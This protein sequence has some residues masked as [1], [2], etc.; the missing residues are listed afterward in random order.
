M[1]KAVPAPA[2]FKAPAL[3]H[4]LHKFG[5][6]LTFIVALTA[7]LGSLYFSEIRLF[8]PC[9]LCWYQRILMYPI[10]PVSLVGAIKKDEYLPYYVLPLSLMGISVSIYH[11]LL[12]NR[13]IP[14][15]DGCTATGVSCVNPPWVAAGFIT[16]A[17][18]ALIAFLII[19]LTMVGTLWA[20]DQV[21]REEE[22]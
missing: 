16:I 9:K 14:E 11:Y 1:T 7:A 18:L 17:F 8:I 13:I 20:N 15:G 10:V 5:P 19:N 2:V 6:I 22:E 12:E 4:F 3:A 21:A